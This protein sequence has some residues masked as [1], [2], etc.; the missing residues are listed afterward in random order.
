MKLAEALAERARMDE[1]IHQLHERA[2]NSARYVEGET[3]PE[4]ARD[5]LSELRAAITARANLIARINMTNATTHVD[6]PLGRMSLTEA[7]TARSKISQEA[8][9]IRE[10]AD[11]ASPGRDPYS[12]TRRKT[13]LPE[14]TDL[15]V[16]EMYT[17]ADAL[18]KYHREL[19][20]SIQQANWVSEL[21]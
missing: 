15:P 21:I 1:K 20:A 10:I 5:L 4:S 2:R 9:Y 8:K 7:L 13:E 18:S 19:D 16:K 12:R 11:Q 17:E 3:P 6:T 14:K